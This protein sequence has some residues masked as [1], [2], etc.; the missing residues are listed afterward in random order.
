[1][2]SSEFVYMLIV[3]NVTSLKFASLFCPINISVLEIII[4]GQGHCTLHM[5]DSTMYSVTLNSACSCDN[6][7]VIKVSIN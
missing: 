2:K 3:V 4:M 7:A 5:C 1:M 6:T